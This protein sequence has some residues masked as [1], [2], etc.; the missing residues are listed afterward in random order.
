MEFPSEFV[1]RPYRQTDRQQL[2]ALWNRV[3][4][5][6]PFWNAPASMVE[7][8]LKVQPELLLVGVLDATIVEAVIAGFDGVG[9]WLYHLAITP[10][11]RRRGFA[12][13]LVR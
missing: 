10:E 13:Q 6:D 7:T 8:K 3:F 4:P 11:Y 12:R 1:V 5:D 2:E 9:G